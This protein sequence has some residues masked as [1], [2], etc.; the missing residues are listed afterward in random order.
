MKT[1]VLC[2]LLFVFA[3]AAS[4]FAADDVVLKQ[5]DI[6]IAASGDNTVIAAVSGKQIIVYKMWFVTNAA[7]NVQFKDGAS[8]AFNGFAVPFT[9]QGS[10]LTFQFDG[11][12][13]F[14]TTAGNAFIINLSGATQITG[15]IYYALR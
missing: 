7:V 2:I 6:N 3:I 8:T 10:S 13:Y 12:S 4:G 14:E 15:R 9:G 1:R 5:A 11:K